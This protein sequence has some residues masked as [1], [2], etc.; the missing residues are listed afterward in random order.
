MLLHPQDLNR[1]LIKS[2]KASVGVPE[3]QFEIPPGT[4]AGVLTTV[5]GMLKSAIEGLEKV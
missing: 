3:L 5:E 4:Q 2:D 1:Q